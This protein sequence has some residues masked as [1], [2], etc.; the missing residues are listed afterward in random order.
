MEKEQQQQEHLYVVFVSFVI[1]VR[2]H[3]T[4]LI[5]V[6]SLPL[7]SAILFDFS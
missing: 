5:Y 4:R 6:S 1:F 7:S 2:F 3:F